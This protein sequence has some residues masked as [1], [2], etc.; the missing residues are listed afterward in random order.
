[1]HLMVPYKVLLGTLIIVGLQGGLFSFLNTKPT[2]FLGTQTISSVSVQP[3]GGGGEV[4][5]YGYEFKFKIKSPVVS[6]NQ[7]IIYSYSV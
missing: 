1:M 5:V 7:I 3:N 6:V 2:F 4:N